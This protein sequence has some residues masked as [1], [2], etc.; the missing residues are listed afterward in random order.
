MSIDDETGGE[1][2]PAFLRCADRFN[3]EIVIYQDR[4]YDHIMANHGELSGFEEAVRLTI[5]QS[6]AIR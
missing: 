5:E 1:D 4:W 3:R 6:D 2:R